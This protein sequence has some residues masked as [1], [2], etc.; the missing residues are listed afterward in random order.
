MTGDTLLTSVKLLKLWVGNQDLTS[1]MDLKKRLN[2]MNATGT[3]LKD[4][5]IIESKLFQDAR[6]FFMESFNLQQFQDIVQ[7]PVEF[8]Q[9]NHSK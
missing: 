3:E 9:D 4:V 2:G 5:Y 1:M 7:Y 8:V 6:G